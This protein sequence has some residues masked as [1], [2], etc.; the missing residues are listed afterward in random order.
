M[1]SVLYSSS[2][3]RDIEAV[4][5]STSLD[6]STP[7]LEPARHHR[8]REI[9]KRRSSN[10]ALALEALK[11]C[12]S[13]VVLR[14]GSSP[15]SSISLL[16]RPCPGKFHRKQSAALERHKKHG[17]IVVITCV[18]SVSKIQY[19]DRSIQQTHEHSLLHCSPVQ[20]HHS[21]LHTRRV[22]HLKRLLNGLPF[23]FA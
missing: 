6:Q 20:T 14:V 16:L 12:A 15:P 13:N 11:A 18:T 21:N 9:L 1:L 22:C 4:P 23:S 7:L 17:G 5:T 19:L 8:Q 3:L 2:S 10:D